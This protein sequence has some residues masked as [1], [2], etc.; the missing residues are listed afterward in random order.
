MQAYLNH[1]TD[2]DDGQRYAEVATVGPCY[3]TDAGDDDTEGDEPQLGIQWQGTVDSVKVGTEVVEY[4]THWGC[5]KV[6]DR[7]PEESVDG[8]IMEYPRGRGKAKGHSQTDDDDATD[9]I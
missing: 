1:G 6:G 4:L 7:C 8:S 9:W 5:L 2:N 3:G